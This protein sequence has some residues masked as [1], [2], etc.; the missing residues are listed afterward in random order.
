[1]NI[2][3]SRFE[4]RSA[5]TLIELLVVIAIIAVLAAMLLPA[6]AAAKSKAQQAKCMA[7]V[8]QM[9]LALV[10]YPTDYQDLLI[11]DI[12]QKTM[13]ASD[14]GAW[15]INL[16]DYYGRAT[17]LFMCPTTYQPNNAISGGAN[18]IAG[19]TITPWASKLPRGGG[20]PYYFGS[21][22]YNGWAFSDINPGTGKHYGDGAG[23]A[24]LPDGVSSGDQGYFGRMSGVRWGST[25]PMFFDQTWTD[26]WPIET[27]PFSRNL[28]GI[29]GSTTLPSG[30]ANSMCRVAKAR[31]GSGGGSKAPDNFTL[32]ASQIPKTYV[33][34]MGFADG[35]AESVK[36]AKLW[37]ITW[38]AKWAQNKVPA[39]NSITPIAG[40]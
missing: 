13:S 40:N 10:M 36:L 28:R 16:I 32:D 14:T 12:D 38:H 29:V 19:D 30:G 39:L 20:N 6:L 17:N 27:S 9:S 15:I 4:R 1:M 11:P 31:H 18:T 8:K 23:I 24:T 25:T 2:C 7:G 21:Y 37:Y 34:N 22:G 33:I 35:H 26:S 5:F 3:V